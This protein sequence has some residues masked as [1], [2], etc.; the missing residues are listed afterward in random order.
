MAA[1]TSAAVA[2]ATALVAASKASNQGADSRSE[3]DAASTMM[4]LATRD[5]PA[6]REM[7]VAG[8]TT[9]VAPAASP[10]TPRT[11]G[12]GKGKGRASHL[13]PSFGIAKTSRSAAPSPVGVMSAGSA[14]TPSSS[15]TQA[16]SRPPA[17]PLASV[18]Q[19]V[20]LSVN[21]H[22]L[23]QGVTP[24]CSG[25]AAAQAP[26]NSTAPRACVAEAAPSTAADSPLRMR[27]ATAAG[28]V[29]RTSPSAG[30]AA[31]RHTARTKGAISGASPVVSGVR[32]RTHRIPAARLARQLKAAGAT[33]AA[34]RLTLAGD[35]AN[36]SSSRV[37]DGAGSP[38]TDAGRLATLPAAA[39]P[40]AETSSAPVLGVATGDRMH[41][42]NAASVV[43][44]TGFN[45]A[46]G[47]FLGV[48]MGGGADGSGAST[49]AEPSTPTARWVEVISAADVSNAGS[50]PPS[51]P[52][53]PSVGG[54]VGGVST[55]GPSDIESG[56][57]SPMRPL[58]WR[59]TRNIPSPVVQIPLSTTPPLP[60]AAT[61]DLGQ[62]TTRATQ[63]V[64]TAV[65]ASTANL[66]VDMAAL[67]ARTKDTAARLQQLV[68]KVDS[69][70]NLSQQTLVA[71]RKVE[72]A[73]KAAISDV[74]KKG[75]IPDKED[76]EATEQQAEKLLD[77]VKVR[78]TPPPICTGYPTWP[79][80]PFLMLTVPSFF[81]FVLCCSLFWFGWSISQKAY[82]GILIN[83]FA[84]AVETVAVFS[85][86]DDNWDT[87]I[88]AAEACMKSGK[89]KAE[90]WLNQFIRR[91][92]RRNASIFVN[93]RVSMLVLR[94]KPHLHQA[95][96]D[97]IVNTYFEALGLQAK[98]L[99]A[100]TAK[101][102][103]EGS[104]YYVS[105]RG[106]EA[107]LDALA[108]LF[109]AVG[110][111]SRITEPTSPTDGRVIRATL[112]HFA[113]VT[114]KIRNVVE[115]A[116]GTRVSSRDGAVG[117]GHFPMWVAEVRRMD[118]S[119]P[120]SEDVL[121][122]LE[123]VDGAALERSLPQY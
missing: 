32:R 116:A 14:A 18:A 25:T 79:I 10:E 76:A 42:D 27:T 62:S 121:D 110:A 7:D 82:R 98:N 96:T 12:K 23:L 111:A 119:F 101:Q 46:N 9:A 68:T 97:L 35:A 65:R 88:D 47:S 33:A 56:P 95:W 48:A 36:G 11:R 41:A 57:P 83:E 59:S 1:A 123:L 49:A 92:S 117:D 86:C 38:A 53:A 64:E 115:L 4:E 39:G 103:M 52:G 120:K 105:V 13:G 85:N 6:P 78:F 108:A 118:A 93:V 67:S 20:G 31:A 40:A 5:G 50:A 102:L 19:P 71:V 113:F 75:A 3:Q 106:R 22:A 30:E 66:R 63:V 89:A 26:R 61:A 94:V 114:T 15:A 29:V 90:A 73:V 74:M 72:A 60:A 28:F 2:A 44:G 70:V 104:A 37:M 55:P 24:L 45:D 17:Y 100:E 81:D 34:H 107:C 77:D 87:V 91:T 122:G 99:D 43:G 109:R 69:S 54:S 51:T 112:G 84:A 58:T 21:P 80:R 8:A 16:A